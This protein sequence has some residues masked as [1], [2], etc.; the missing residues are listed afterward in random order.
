MTL[1]KLKIGNRGSGKSVTLE[2]ELWDLAWYREV[3]VVLFDR[4][5]LLARSLTGRNASH[6]REQGVVFD[7]ARPMGGRNLGWVYQ[8]RCDNADPMVRSNDER[9]ADEELLMALFSKRDVKSPGSMPLANKGFKNAFRV[10]RGIVHPPPIWGVHHLFVR[11]DPVGQW[12]VRTTADRE[13]AR[14]FIEG[15]EQSARDGGKQWEFL[16]G[17][18]ERMGE[19][20]KSPTMIAHDDGCFSW[21]Q[22]I[23]EK[24]QIYFDLSGVTADDARTF[25]ILAC[26]KIIHLC[27]QNLAR[28]GRPLPVVIVLEEAG[29]LDLVTP[30]IL[31]AMQELRAAGVSVWVVTQTLFDFKPE[32]MESLLSLCDVH[33][34]FRI[35][36]G[37]ERAAQD[38]AYATWD[39]HRVHHTKEVTY[40]AGHEQ[41]ETK[42][43][44]SH[45]DGDR[46]S[47][48]EA[49][50]PI[51]NV[52]VEETYYTPQQHEAEFR[53]R[54]T[55]L[56]TFERFIRDKQGVRREFVPP[57]ENP[58]FLG[59][60][61]L[62]KRG[63]T[64]GERNTLLAIERIRSR[65]YYTPP[66]EW[67]LPGDPPSV[68]AGS[69]IVPPSNGP[70]RDATGEL[71]DE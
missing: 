26:S 51:L 13:A 15:A 45:P 50:R 41:V 37:I 7:T 14:V 3:A 64:A 34:F 29:A 69:P 28:T 25:A 21:V 42:T 43:V 19:V 35:N 12:M 65:P 36:S 6:K 46:V 4:P 39:S 52:R 20:F 59:D 44:T 66:V 61:Y 38:L 67:T 62:P 18:S 30:V 56:Q 57:L 53:E 22:A 60:E 8:E 48:G 63:M 54:L 47:T 32:V 1:C 68:A 11:N 10:R 58:W 17:P 24:M 40:T 33:E 31:T 2:R 71:V 16:F 27:R 70:L 55:N 5:G 9:M 23:R 49:S